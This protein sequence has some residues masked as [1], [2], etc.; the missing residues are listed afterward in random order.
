MQTTLLINTS[1]FFLCT[2]TL[3][4]TM[5]SVQ[6]FIS[7]DIFDVLIYKNIQFAFIHSNTRRYRRVIR[8]HHYCVN[9]S[10]FSLADV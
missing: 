5:C 8:T 10:N 1:G 6:L 9:E 3:K 4:T 2:V 7:K